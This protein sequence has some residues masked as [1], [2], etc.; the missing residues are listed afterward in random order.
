MLSCGYYFWQPLFAGNSAISRL[1][2]VAPECTYTVDCGLPNFRFH[3]VMHCFF[4]ATNIVQLQVGL[5]LT[6]YL[7]LWLITLP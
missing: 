4:S 7:S 3:V 2:I 6:T 1:Q 5:H